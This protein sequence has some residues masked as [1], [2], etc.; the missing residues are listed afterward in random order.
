LYLLCCWGLVGLVWS[1]SSSLL[2]FGVV[3]S[4][5]DRF[6]WFAEFLDAFGNERVCFVRH[7]AAMS[8]TPATKQ[9]CAMRPLALAD[10]HSAPAALTWVGQLRGE[11]V[12]RINRDVRATWRIGRRGKRV[13]LYCH[14]CK[15]LRMRPLVHLN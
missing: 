11:P 3:A 12:Q 1:L 10:N 13:K 8:F 14:R 4:N 5:S 9:S 7:P 15:S 2:S 6:S